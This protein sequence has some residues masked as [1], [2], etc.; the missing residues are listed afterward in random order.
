MVK[1]GMLA[2]DG[3]VDDGADYLVDNAESEIRETVSRR[4]LQDN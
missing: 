4:R 1:T 2:G 3:I